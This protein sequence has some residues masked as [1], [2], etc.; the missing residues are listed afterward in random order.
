LNESPRPGDDRLALKLTEQQKPLRLFNVMVVP[1][2][3]PWAIVRL[4]G[5]ALMVKSITVTAIVME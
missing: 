2:D 5:L 3:D 4:V 1:P